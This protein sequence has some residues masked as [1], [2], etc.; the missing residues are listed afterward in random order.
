MKLDNSNA[1]KSQNKKKLGPYLIAEI[2]VNHEGNLQRAFKLVELA[3][4]GGADAVKFQ[5]YK[6]EL[7][8]VKNAKSYWDLKCEP[9][10]SQYKLFKKYDVFTND[11]YDKIYKFCN[12]LDIEFLSTPF[13]LNSVDFLDEYVSKF[14]VASADITN[15]PLLRHIGSK[16]KPVIISTGASEKEEIHLA[17][18]ELEKS[19]SG[20]VALLHCVLNYPTEI[21]NANLGMISLLHNLFPN[22]IIGYSD[23]TLPDKNMSSLIAAQVLGAQIIEKHFTNDKF[24]KG[25]DHYHS[26]DVNDLKIFI[27]QSEKIVKLIGNSTVKNT[28][29]SE[30]I[31]R[32]NARR[33]IVAACDLKKGDILTEKNL[34]T[35]RP[36]TGISPTDWDVVIGKK[37]MRD[38]NADSILKW[39]DISI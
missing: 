3:K 25:N 39:S 11:D 14:K 31:S 23:H 12:N 36:G 33:S 22:Q 8:T 4:Q 20:P 24:L 16:K 1:F 26:M 27:S 38:L 18:N 15:I 5:T 21:E 17:L 37:I 19:G 35:K 6:A 32:L 10:D 13:D 30:E 2:G 34:I 9:Q 7:L 29:K 28:L